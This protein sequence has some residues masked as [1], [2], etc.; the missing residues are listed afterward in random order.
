MEMID[1]MFFS[2]IVGILA[3]IGIGYM[4]GF[5]KGA[6]AMIEKNERTTQEPTE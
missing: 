1:A 5:L 6:Y 2:L 4:I 3:G